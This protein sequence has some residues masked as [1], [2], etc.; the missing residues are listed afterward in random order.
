MLESVLN[1]LRICQDAG[2]I[3]QRV[4]SWIHTLVL[5]LTFQ[6]YFWTVY[7]DT[8]HGER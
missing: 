5:G 8:E 4:M 7:L 3:T 6:P 1:F 2:K